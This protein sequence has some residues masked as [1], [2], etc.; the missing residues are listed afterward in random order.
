MEAVFVEVTK[1]DGGQV[2]GTIASD[3]TTVREYHLGQAHSFLETE[4]VDWT[5][6]N[7]DGT[8]EGN[9]VG[10]FL[11]EWQKSPH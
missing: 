6:A 11:A 3:L 4:V 10:R 8:Q 1:I 7:A 5:I 9:I 2:A